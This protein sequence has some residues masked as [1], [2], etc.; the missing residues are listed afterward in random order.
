M[1]RLATD[2]V[3]LFALGTA[4]ISRLDR[5]SSALLILVLGA[6]AAVELIT[7]PIGR[8]LS[9]GTVLR[10]KLV[11]AILAMSLVAI[12]PTISGMVL[13]HASEKW[14]YVHD[15]TIQIEESIRFLLHGRNPYTEDYFETPLARWEYAFPSPA[16]NP[17]LYHNAYLP[18]IFLFSAPF[19]VISTWLTGWY[20]QRLVF[21]LLFVAA[22]WLYMLHGSSATKRLSLLIVFGL[23][24]FGVSYVIWGGTDVFVLFW[25]IA[26]TYLIRRNR[27][28]AAAVCL[29]L[30]CASKQTAWLFV[31]FFLVHSWKKEQ[32][33]DTWALLRA[34]APVILVPA[35]LILPFLLWDAASFV[36]D[37]YLYLSGQSTS[38]YPIT[39]LGFGGLLVDLGFVKDSSDYFPFI[40]FQLVFC[41][42][43]LIVLLRQ[44]WHH[45]TL[46]RCW[47]GYGLLLL[48][49]TFFSRFF[50]DFYLGTIVNAVAL[51]CLAEGGRAEIDTPEGGRWRTTASTGPAL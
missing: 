22:S 4:C 41:I 19:Y 35:L 36:D 40:L 16:V 1:N 38:S 47:F 25:L 11:L 2:T 49:F 45:S 5:T 14:L 48:C 30:A 42:P 51:G 21:L 33:S 10:S 46:Q 6:Y 20:D 26:C 44:Q 29:G 37:T 7:S 8:R 34:A 12:V 43:L 18:F 28:T 32:P 23:N 24:F 9:A 17:A 39:G 50:S 15:G 3:I 31:P 13:R 27:P